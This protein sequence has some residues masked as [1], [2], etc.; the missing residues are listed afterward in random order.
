VAKKKLWRV[1]L[2]EEDQSEIQLVYFSGASLTLKHC[3]VA[4]RSVQC[5]TKGSKRVFSFLELAA[6]R[7]GFV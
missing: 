2:G 6:Y 4:K 5:K 7:N 1:F 3:P